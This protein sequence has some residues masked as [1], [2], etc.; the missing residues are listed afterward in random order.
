MERD[1]YKLGH[2]HPGNRPGNRAQGIFAKVLA[3]AASAVLLVSS[4]ALSLIVFAFALTLLLAG[5]LYLW[6]KTR[7]LRKHLRTQSPQKG[8]VIEGE[9]IREVDRPDLPAGAATRSPSSSK[10]PKS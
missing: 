7:A 3:V 6:W 5:G 8:V 10:N 9:V 2:G 4:I 1:T